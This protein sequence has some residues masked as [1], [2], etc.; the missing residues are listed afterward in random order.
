[1]FFSNCSA[2]YG[3]VIITDHKIMLAE[4]AR[5][6]ATLDDLMPLVELLNKA[7]RCMG[8]KG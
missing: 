1:M 2:S 7:R 3:N 4:C 6:H 5:Q 8:L